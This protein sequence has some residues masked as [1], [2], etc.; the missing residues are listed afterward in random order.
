MKP[1][2]PRVEFFLKK[3]IIYDRY[4]SGQVNSHSTRCGPSLHNN[5]L[6]GGCHSWHAS[7]DNFQT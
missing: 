7:K 1:E 5:T 6:H 3:H 4:D 2:I